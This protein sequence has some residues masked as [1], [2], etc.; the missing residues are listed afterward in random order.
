MSVQRRDDRERKAGDAVEQP[1]HA[2]VHLDGLL[3]RADGTQLF[4]VAAGHKGSVS[5]APYDDDGG[6]RC[7]HPVESGP[8]L[9]HGGEADGVADL[10]PVDGDDGDACP[11]LDADTAHG[12]DNNALLS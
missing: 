11:D 10:G 1:A 6:V 3:M 9:V 12:G 7:Q 4:E 5:P 2:T 8:E